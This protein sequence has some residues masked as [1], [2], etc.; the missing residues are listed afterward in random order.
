MSDVEVKKSSKKKKEKKHKK[1]KKASKKRKKDVNEGAINN[2]D[3]PNL[4]RKKGEADSNT[5]SSDFKKVK[6]LKKE[7]KSSKKVKKDANGESKVKTLA[8][9]K[10]RSEV[11]ESNT[12]E[13]KTPFNFPVQYILAPMVG[14][15]EL[16]FRILCRKYGAQTCYTPMMSST[17]FA[18]DPKY[19]A[20]EFQTI[21]EDRPLVC[22]FSA[23]DP[24]EF[25]EAAKLVQDRC[26]AIDLK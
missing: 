20:E 1:E 7:K 18:T 26:D 15:S 12:M 25:T 11:N 6:K 21:K 8:P 19:R 22:H 16:P 4:K 5:D 3:E 2:E 17:K 24:T 9:L 23:N 10:D 13:R 14:A